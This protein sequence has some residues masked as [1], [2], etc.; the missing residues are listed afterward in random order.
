MLRIMFFIVLLFSVSAHSQGLGNIDSLKKLLTNNELDDTSRVKVLLNLADA[1]LYNDP[2][3]AMH[4]TNQAFALAEKIPWQMGIALSYRQK[5]NVYYLASD[6]LNAM[7][8]FQKALREGASLKNEKLDATVYNNIANIY[9]DMKQYNKA[10]DNYNLLLT[11][12]RTNNMR[13]EETIALINLGTVYTELENYDKALRLFSNGLV[14]AEKDSNMRLLPFILSNMGMLYNKKEMYNE[15]LKNFERSIQ[16]ADAENSNNSKEPAFEGMAKAYLGLKNITK[17]EQFGNLALKSA[18]AMGSVEWQQNS[19]EILS[20]VY[21]AQHKD[22]KALQTYKKY[23]LYRDSVLSD[24]KKQELTRKEMEFDFENKTAL[25]KAEHNKQQAVA[26]EKIKQ[27]AIVKNSALAGAGI[28]L[29]AG[30]STFVFYKRKRDA[31]DEKIEANFKAQEAETEMK[32]LRLQMNP[33]FIFNSLNSISN[34]IS[35]HDIK[36]ADDYLTGF[37]KLMRMMLEYSEKKAISLQ[38]DLKALELY[39]QLEMLRMNHAFTYEIKVDENIDKDTTLVPPMILQPFVENSIW[40][41]IA[42]KQS[43]GKICIEI[44]KEDEMINC[45]VED[46][47]AGRMKQSNESERRSLGMK[48][49]KARID[50]LNRI[51]KSKAGVELTDLTQGLRVEVKLPLE[52]SF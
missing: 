7:D 13:K 49:T 18:E 26:E 28:L 31:E 43:E 21:E 42:T 38:E 3:T 5:G 29:F 11:T 27:Q 2:D 34:Y 16:L 48:I 33:H 46:N 10:L 1:V 35:R 30:I 9:S 51:K 19:W 52:L 44:K 24:E 12:A 45:I 23:V 37:A 50:M 6:N 47:G 17:A 39:M 41:G 20:A 25:I 4:Y 36:M 14:I 22:S 32:V 15:A 40:H 8:C